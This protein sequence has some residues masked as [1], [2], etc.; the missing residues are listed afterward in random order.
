MLEEQRRQFSGFAETRGI[1]HCRLE[2]QERLDALIRRDLAAAPAAPQGQA[3]QRAIGLACVRARH[4][5]PEESLAI[6]RN[7]L[8][9]L[10]RP[11]PVGEWKP[12]MLLEVP[13]QFPQ[14]LRVERSDRRLVIVAVDPQHR[15]IRPVG[16]LPD[17]DQFH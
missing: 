10:P 12:Q 16:I 15:P 14:S 17:L 4:Q 5:L 3:L 13:V 6:S 8:P 11:H 2:T 9:G 1:I 7:T